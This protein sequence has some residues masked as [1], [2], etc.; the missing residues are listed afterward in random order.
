[1]ACNFETG[2][3]KIKLLIEYESLTQKVL[4]GNRTSVELLFHIPQA[5]LF[6]YFR[7]NHPALESTNKT[8]VRFTSNRH[9]TRQEDKRPVSPIHRF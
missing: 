6:Y 2:N 4:T 3:N 8:N 7:E 9:E 5:V 1:V